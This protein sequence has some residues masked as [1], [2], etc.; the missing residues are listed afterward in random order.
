MILLGKKQYYTT[1]ENIVRDFKEYMQ[2]R[3]KIQIFNRLFQSTNWYM[4]CCPFHKDGNEQKPSFGINLDSGFYNC[5]TCGRKGNI[6]DLID[7]IFIKNS[8]NETCSSYIERTYMQSQNAILTFQIHKQEEKTKPQEV[9]AITPPFTQSTTYD[10]LKSR[11][12][13][14]EIADMYGV[15]EDNYYVYFNVYDLNG[16]WKYTTKRAKFDKKFYI[17][18]FATKEVYLGNYFINDTRPIAIC[19]SQFN[20]L[21]FLEHN[22][23]AVALFGT[24]DE[25]Q[26]SILRKFATTQFILALDNDDAGQHGKI[27]LYEA[28]KDKYMIKSVVYGNSGLDINDYH[29]LGNFDKLKFKWGA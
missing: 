11:G 5:F 8:I 24:G 16:I 2:S 22:I 25:R 27:K 3:Y 26:Y 10:Y 17:P 18:K 19:E 6:E 23:P 13:T 9:D 12:I 15:V 29:K 21:S 1:Y 28:L 4:C 7:N 14:K 20:A